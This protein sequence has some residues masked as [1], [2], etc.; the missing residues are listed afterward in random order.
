[1]H[2]S[3]HKPFLEFATCEEKAILYVQFRCQK[4]PLKYLPG[5][6]CAYVIFLPLI[7]FL[8]EGL[9]RFLDSS[10]KSVQDFLTE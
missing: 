2:F 4:M 8:R 5:C 10:I 3:V 6:V 9:Y 1:M 7:F